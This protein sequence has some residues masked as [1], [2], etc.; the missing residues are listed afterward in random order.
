[1]EKKKNLTKVLDHTTKLL[2]GDK[3]RHCFLVI[4]CIIETFALVSSIVDPRGK[5]STTSR[6]FL[7]EK[8]FSETTTVSKLGEASAALSEGITSFTCRQ[9]RSS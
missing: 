5:I 9:S 1:M 4:M 7:N 3:S 8:P 2:I 6:I